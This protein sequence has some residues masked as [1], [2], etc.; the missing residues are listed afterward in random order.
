MA[1][2][3]STMFRGGSYKGGKASPADLFNLDGELESGP[4]VWNPDQEFL[5]YYNGKLS[6]TQLAELAQQ[7]LSVDTSNLSTE[8]PKYSSPM[9]A[10]FTRVPQGTSNPRRPRV[11]A[12]GWMRN[13]DE[14]EGTL[15][16]L[17]RDGTVWSYHDVPES[18]WEQFSAAPT[19]FP[20]IGGGWQEREGLLDAAEYGGEPANMS[21]PVSKELYAMARAIQMSGSH[22]SYRKKRRGK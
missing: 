1:S 18:V 4:G 8:T 5:D 6:P 2:A 17:F 3:F 14:D 12:S 7:Y 19:T 13:E 11:V 16:V 15:T 9:R 10:P 20:W 22:Q 21:E